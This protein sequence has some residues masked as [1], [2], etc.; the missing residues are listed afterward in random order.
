MSSSK[1]IYC[2]N[3]T[4]KILVK[5]HFQLPNPKTERK[6]AVIW[7]NKSSSGYRIYTFKIML[8]VLTISLEIVFK[9]ACKQ[10]FLCMSQSKELIRSLK[11][12]QLN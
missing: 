12:S 9:L 8:H 4:G 1:T 10:N 6:R 2:N 7:L 5:T 11:L 3:T